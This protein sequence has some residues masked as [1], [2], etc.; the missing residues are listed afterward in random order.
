[1]PARFGTGDCISGIA[2]SWVS[3][4]RF[5]WACAPCLGDAVA[6]RPGWQNPARNRSTETRQRVQTTDDAASGQRRRRRT[7]GSRHNSGRYL[8]SLE[9]GLQLFWGWVF[10]CHFESASREDRA[11]DER[12]RLVC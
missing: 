7:C 11:C 6:V 2:G 12:G 3:R 1:M 5:S 9:A 10:S 4:A 8:L